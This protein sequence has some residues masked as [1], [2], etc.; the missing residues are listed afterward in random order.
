MNA[1]RN[2]KSNLPPVGN[3]TMSDIDEPT[4]L[5]HENAIVAGYEPLLL[6]L[7]VVLYPFL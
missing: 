5:F 3:I 7:C 4:I 2:C 6:F 1:T